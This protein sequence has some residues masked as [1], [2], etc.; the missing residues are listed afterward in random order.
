[1]RVIE[2]SEEVRAIIAE[3][4]THLIEGHVYWSVKMRGPGLRT[5]NVY[6]L[7]LNTAHPDV[8]ASLAQAHSSE[9][10]ASTSELLGFVKTLL[11]ITKAVR[12]RSY[13]VAAALTSQS[14]N[15]SS[16]IC[17]I[18]SSNNLPSFVFMGCLEVVE[19][20]NEG[21]NHA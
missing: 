17:E 3:D 15:L 10:T 7:D 11:A 16:S 12:N 8:L 14:G 9:N 13:V 19:I 18:L 6:T 1:M 4:D 21:K 2:P 5:T 20:N